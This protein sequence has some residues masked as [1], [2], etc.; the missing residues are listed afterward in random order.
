LSD[1]YGDALARINPGMP[2]AGNEEVLRHV[3]T[4][5]SPAL[6]ENNR[7]FQQMLTDGGCVLD[8]ER[9]GTLWQGINVLNLRICRLWMPLIISDIK[10][11]YRGADQDRKRLVEKG[12][13]NGEKN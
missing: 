2:Q 10:V 4:P 6:I 11:F 7:R 5:E 3:L 12:E 9:W 13:K 8:G 1:V